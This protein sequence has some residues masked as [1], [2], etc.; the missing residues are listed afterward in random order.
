MEKTKE[1]EEKEKAGKEIFELNMLE[2]RLRELEQQVA[3][4]E[5]QVLEQQLLEQNLEE[6][7]EK[8]GEEVKV[9]L[10]KGVFV[11][12][13]LENVKKVLVDVGAKVVL[14]KNI[15]DAKKIVQKRKEKLLKLSESL[16]AE[17]Q[18]AF[19]EITKLEMKIS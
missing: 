4:V 14:E 6:I 11:P 1:K 13:K 19:A 2:G 17:M 3:I 7:K 8:K 5:Q 12:A 10:G 16:N 9:P 15:E 18:K